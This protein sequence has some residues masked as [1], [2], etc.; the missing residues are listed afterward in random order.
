MGPLPSGVLGLGP[1]VGLDLGP[2]PLLRPG[3]GELVRLSGAGGLETLGLLGLVPAHPN[4]LCLRVESPVGE[5]CLPATVVDWRHCRPPA[6]QTVAAKGGRRRR[7][8]PAAASG[9]PASLRSAG[10]STKARR[11][12]GARFFGGDGAALGGGRS[13][14]KGGADSRNHLAG[15]GSLRGRLN[16]A[17]RA[18]PL[19]GAKGEFPG[20]DCCARP[21]G[22]TLARGDSRCRWRSFER[23]G[24]TFAAGDRLLVR[25][26]FD[27]S[28]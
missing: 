25:G 13:G 12:I 24:G 8:A 27:R 14:T 5:L 3:L 7:R 16:R 4:F 18:R 6:W 9:T 2:R 20:R 1:G 26:A 22:R 28:L 21:A 10:C 11:R 15:A 23:P 19:P 17:A